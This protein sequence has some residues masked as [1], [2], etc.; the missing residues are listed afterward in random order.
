MKSILRFLTD[1]L[2]FGIAGRLKEAQELRERLITEAE[3][4][5][6]RLILEGR[7]ESQKIRESIESE[8][9]ERRQELQQQEPGDRAV[10]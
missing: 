1:R 8:L 9:R 7:E 3:E 5:K 4:Q 10:H 6:R 2:G